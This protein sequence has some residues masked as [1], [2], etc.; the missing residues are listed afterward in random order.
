MAFAFYGF[1]AFLLFLFLV[2]YAIVYLLF[3]EKIDRYMRKRR[4]KSMH[5]EK[6]WHKCPYS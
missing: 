4:W 5:D 1:L 3:G 6:D 2:P